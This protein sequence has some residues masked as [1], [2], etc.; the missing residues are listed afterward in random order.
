MRKLAIALSAGIGLAAAT[1]GLAAPA[2]ASTSALTSAPAVVSSL[3]A[4][5][6]KPIPNRV[7]THVLTVNTTVLP[8]CSVHANY[9]GADVNV[10]WC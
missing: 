6:Y 3:G 5:T 7:D 8:Q 2:M 1:V 10:N 9:N 4:T